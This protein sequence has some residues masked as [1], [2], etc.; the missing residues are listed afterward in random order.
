MMS[1][2]KPLPN[3][4]AMKM[5]Q[6]VAVMTS[7]LTSVALDASLEGRDGLW[8]VACSENSWLTAAANEHGIPSRR[9]NFAQGYDIYKPETWMRLKEERRQRRPKK[10]WLSLPCT[11]FC[12]WTQVNYNTPERK[13][14]LESMRRR[15]RRML[16][17]VA[18]FL[19]TALDEDPDL[20]VYWEWTYPC[21]GWQQGPMVKLEQD[22]QKRGIAWESCRID[23]CNYGLM[24]S[25][26]EFVLHKK[27]LIKT[28]DELFWKNFRQ[29]CAPETIPTAS[30]KA[31]KQA[32]LPITRRGWS[33]ALFDIGNVNLLLF[34]TSS[35]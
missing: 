7:T 33:K 3:N 4:I 25:K 1:S 23:G 6:M 35:S 21:S 2:R 30:F 16:R 5:M 10:I 12:I 11:K 9:I 27:W 28:T 31:W 20:D 29:K 17:W 14:V 26:N 15:E 34:D 24:D 18:D 19:V 13:E 32:E 22:L 8:E